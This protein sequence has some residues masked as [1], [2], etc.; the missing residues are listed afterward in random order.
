MREPDHRCGCER[1][2]APL[3]AGR[4]EDGSR[5]AGPEARA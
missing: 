3:G 5:A 4:G 2:R 1:V